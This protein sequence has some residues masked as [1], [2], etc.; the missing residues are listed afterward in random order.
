MKAVV[1]HPVVAQGSFVRVDVTEWLGNPLSTVNAGLNL[2]CENNRGKA[3]SISRYKRD[4]GYT[5]YLDARTLP[6]GKHEILLWESRAFSTQVKLEFEIRETAPID[7]ETVKRLRHLHWY[8]R[9]WLNNM[10][11]N[12]E[13]LTVGELLIS[14][15]LTQERI[16][17]WY[18][19]TGH[20]N[21]LYPQEMEYGFQALCKTIS[22]F[23]DSIDNI[24][25][26]ED[27]AWLKENLAG[28]HNRCPIGEVPEDYQFDGQ[29]Y[30]SLF[31]RMTVC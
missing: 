18:R 8:L 30:A 26:E 13:T 1:S 19:K 16:G 20:V 3:V 4:E 24:V 17:I 12:H 23:G 7:E 2:H 6:I 5:C 22:A 25:Q 9:A 27:L 14:P 11:C 28:E 21:Y 15:D 29:R 10:V 31:K